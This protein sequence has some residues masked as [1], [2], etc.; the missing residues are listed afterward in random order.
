MNAPAF[1]APTPGIRAVMSI[2]AAPFALIFGGG[3]ALARAR[4]IVRR[5]SE[6]ARSSQFVNS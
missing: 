5:M 4:K 1:A 3:T 2:D 6:D